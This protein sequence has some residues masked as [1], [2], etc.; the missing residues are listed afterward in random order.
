MFIKH[1]AIQPIQSKIETPYYL[2]TYEITDSELGT[3]TISR[4][5][6]GYL[7]CA[8][9]AIAEFYE[10]KEMNVAAQL[11]LFIRNM[12]GN[13]GTQELVMRMIE[14]REKHIYAKYISSINRYLMLT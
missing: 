5:G 2:F 6:M 4:I 1:R 3:V 9:A 12:G 10:S 8:F 14:T 11:A 7:S 13:N